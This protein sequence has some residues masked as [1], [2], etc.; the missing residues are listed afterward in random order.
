MTGLARAQ[1]LFFE[2]LEAQQ[3]QR[4]DHAEELYREALAAAPDRPS[5]LNNL[6]TVLL[7]LQRPADAEAPARR[8]T[9]VDPGAAASWLTLGNVQSGL[10]RHAEAASSYRRALELDRGNAG[11]HKNL[12]LA[13]MALGE[14]EDALRSFDGALALEPRMAD[15]LASRGVILSELGRLE[16]ALDNCRAAAAIDPGNA[17]N[18]ARLGNVLVRMMRADEAAQVCDRALAIDPACADARLNRGNARLLLARYADALEDFARTRLL[19]PDDPKAYWNE[20]LCR[21]LLG[22]F[23]GGWKLFGH[24]WDT[25]QRGGQRPP[26][27]QPAWQGGR[28]DGCL[29]VWGEQGIGDQMLF[30]GMLG[31][32]LPLVRKLVVA[33]DRRLVALLQRSLPAARIIAYEDLPGLEGVDAQVAM[34]DLGMHL[35]RNWADFPA[36]RQGYLKADAARAAALRQ[37]NGGGN[38]LLCGIS[39]RSHNAAVGELKSMALAELAAIIGMPGLRCIDLQYG[40]TGAERRALREQHGLELV[41]CDDIDNFSDIDGLAALIEAC[42]IVVSVSNT[43]VHLA[44]ALGKPALVMLPHALGRIWYWHEGRDRSPWYPSCTLLRQPAAG[45]WT[46]VLT[47]A[48]SLLESMLAARPAGGV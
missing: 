46:P 17:V 43:T 28:V 33:V 27:T 2:A 14:R 38:P 31:E 19:A 34:G 3:A 41:H 5:L 9:E 25:G 1:Q 12:G 37:R 4:L 42:D 15:A 23:S 13:L 29:L 44:G 39:W 47:R 24:G 35:R 45:D 11:L 10:H 18:L 36:G 22:D 6:A 20:S 8:L 30:A 48:K 16:E 21:L 32:L 26:F 7:Q 40:D